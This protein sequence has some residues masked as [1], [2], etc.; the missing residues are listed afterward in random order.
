MTFQELQAA[1]H[2]RAVSKGWWDD[3]KEH[4][5]DIAAKLALVHS[6]VSEAL[7]CLRDG[8]MAMD[9]EL[10]GKPVGFATELADI[11]IR[12]M[13]LAEALGI[14]LWATMLEKDAY[15]ATRQHRHGGRAL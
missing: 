4:A 15:N 11:V 5:N 6:E 12:V 1:I 10:G 14:D 13:D 7:E 2:K 3:G 8:Q 9:Y